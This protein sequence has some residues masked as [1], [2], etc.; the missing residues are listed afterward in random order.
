MKSIS[1]KE[2]KLLE[3]LDKL[4]N[5]DIIKPDKIIE[6]ENLANQKNQLEIEKKEDEFSEKIDE[7]NQET[8]NLMEEIDKWQM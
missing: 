8:D 2:K 1:E 4:K 6:L 3:T 5:I 7:L